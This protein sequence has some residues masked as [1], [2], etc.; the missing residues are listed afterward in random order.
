MKKLAISLTVLA[1]AAVAVPS[2]NA[3]DN[4]TTGLVGGAVAGAVV[5][6]PVGAVI[7]GAAGYTIGKE[8]DKDHRQHRIYRKHHR[9]YDN[10]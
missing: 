6:G 2:A 4:K 9:V 8:I 3:A 5:G 10:N 7:G 1:F